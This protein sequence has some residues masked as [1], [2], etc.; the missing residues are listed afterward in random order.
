MPVKETLD[1]CA[2]ALRKLEP[3]TYD[4]RRRTIRRSSISHLQL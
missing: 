1:E 3:E 4:G 2:F